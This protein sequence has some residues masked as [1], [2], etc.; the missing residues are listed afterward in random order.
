MKTTKGDCS[1]EK[2]TWTCCQCDETNS[3][4]DRKCSN[5]ACGH[6]RCSTC[7]GLDVGPPD[8]T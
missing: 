5:S 4:E 2:K 7:S 6:I 3:V 1:Y 8:I